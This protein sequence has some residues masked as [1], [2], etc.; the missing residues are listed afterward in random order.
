MI[1][2]TMMF[3][4][5]VHTANWSP[6]LQALEIFTKYFF[7]HDRF[8]YSWMIPLYLAGMKSLKS[9]DHDINAEFQNGNWVVNQKFQR[10]LLWSWCRQRTGAHQPLHESKRRLG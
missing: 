7:V 2:E 9:T 6:H 10:I 1:L 5:A 8:N 3:I 4:R